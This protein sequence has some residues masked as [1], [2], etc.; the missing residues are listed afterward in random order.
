MKVSVLT[1]LYHVTILAR[2]QGRAMIEALQQM[3]QTTV[4]TTTEHQ[5]TAYHF[6]CQAFHVS[7]L[8]FSGALCL[9]RN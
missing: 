1:T 4:P 6:V 3:A 2:V 9:T 8:Y 5:P 7:S